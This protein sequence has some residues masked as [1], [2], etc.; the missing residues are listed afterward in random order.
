MAQT[1]GRC[2]TQRA[3]SKRTGVVAMIQAPN[4]TKAQIEAGIVQGLLPLIEQGQVFEVRV[5][6]VD[7]NSKRV[8]AGYFDD[9]E[10]AVKAIASYDGRAEGIYIIPN[11][12]NP[13]LLARAA[14]RI[15]PYLKSTTSDAD[16]LRR[17]YFLLDADPTRPSGISSTDEELEAAIAR[18]DAVC[19]WLALDGWPE[20]KRGKSGNGAHA[21]YSIDLP[22]DPDIGLIIERCLKALSEKFSDAKVKIDTTV[23]NP[24]RIWKCYG[25]TA[26]KGDSI[27]TR[28]HRRSALT[29]VPEN[30]EIVTLEQLTRLAA[31]CEEQPSAPQR[32]NQSNGT[33]DVERWLESHN[34][35]YE[36][37]KPRYGGWIWKLD[38]C[39]F[40]DD[41]TDGAF[42]IQFPSGA[43]SAGCHHDRCKGKG[44]KDL[45]ELY[46]GKPE[47]RRK[48]K[49]A[50][51]KIQ[52]LPAP[53]TTATNGNG[54]HSIDPMPDDTYLPEPSSWFDKPH[55]TDMGNAQ[56]MYAFAKDKVLYVPHF[57][58]WYTW[59]GT[60]WQEDNSYAVLALAKQTVRHM[61]TELIEID[62]D[63]KRKE[64]L[65][66]IVQSESRNR[67]ESMI[68]LLRS[69]PGISIGPDSLDKHPMLLPVKNGT[70][71]LTTGDLLPSDPAHKL[72][73][74][75]DV[76]YD[77]SAECPLWEKFLIRIMGSNLELVSFIQR[78]AGHALTGDA[79]GKYM[80]FMWG[81][82]GN[83]GKSTLVETLMKLLGPY[84]MKSPTEMVMAKAYRGGVPNDIARLRGVRF[85]V[86]NEV[87]EGMTL[88]ESVIKDLTGYDTLTARFMRGEFFDFLPTHKLWIYGNHKPEI[89]G[90]DTAI[91]DRVKLIPFEIEIPKDERDPHLLDKLTQELP[92]ILAWAVKGCLMWQKVGINAPEIVNIATSEYRAEQDM[93]GQFL[94]DCC[95]TGRAF[96]VGAGTIYQA[97]EAWCKEMGIKPETGHKFGAEL[98]RR[99]F[100]SGKMA[101]IRSR[102]GLRLNSQGQR[103]LGDVEIKKHWSEDAE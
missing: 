42:V 12:I 102:Q 38:K 8:D 64:Q 47:D 36:D 26:G 60:H 59:V 2:D 17:R 7:D 56:R 19:E 6:G 70:I 11:E 89:R 30:L 80:V 76:E 3:P 82:K 39:H 85:T 14:N 90:T 77:P 13:A 61:Y 40:S 73:M 63:D 27:P 103:L 88:S 4:I 94:D 34:I 92:G 23:S 52:N 16:I 20:P 43:I 33:L 101:G 99:G 24:A 97:Y 67:L 87:D 22:N 98:G 29:S 55:N 46:D 51:T 10:K 25:T 9:I 57:G 58:K 75:L 69:E 35:G 5:V 53:T 91:W 74:R 78:L 96:E 1:P 71:D 86:T 21:L 84:A 79:T 62:D 44:W 50:A 41:H 32:T 15:K 93:L 31:M 83:N 95:D 28:P 45:R 49:P 72:T 81:P 100:K 66:W 54:V 65:K 68:A 37:K 48:V 18:M